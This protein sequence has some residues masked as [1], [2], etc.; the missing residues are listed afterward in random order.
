M[1][2]GAYIELPLPSLTVGSLD[3]KKDSTGSLT[4]A[5]RPEPQTDACCVLDLT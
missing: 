4:S 5:S 1:T 3:T 2:Y